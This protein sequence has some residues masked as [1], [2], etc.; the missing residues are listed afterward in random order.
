MAVLQRASAFSSCGSC[1]LRGSEELQR[2]V[3]RLSAPLT[4]SGGVRGGFPW[5]WG[6]PGARQK[7]WSV[8]SFK[9]GFHRKTTSG[10]H[11]NM[12]S[13]HWKK[14]LFE[15]APKPREK[16]KI[17]YKKISL[18]SSSVFLPISRL[19][20]HLQRRITALPGWCRGKP[21]AVWFPPTHLVAVRECGRRSS[22]IDRCPLSTA[23]LPF[24][25]LFV[26]LL[27]AAVVLTV[28]S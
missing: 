22:V 5:G 3:H 23:V 14:S 13:N 2:W 28:K 10:G 16:A 26:P 24:L 1:N 27:V 6:P 9:V 11:W 17:W 25:V 4:R 15:G 12:T 20:P 18:L 8:K 7:H 21:S 19:G